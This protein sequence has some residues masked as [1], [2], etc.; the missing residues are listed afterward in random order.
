MKTRA[1]LVVVAVTA[2]LALAGCGGAASS[3]KTAKVDPAVQRVLRLAFFSDMATADPNVFYDIEG[4]AISQSVYDGLLRYRAGTTELEGALAE[5]WKVSGDRRT[6]T[7]ALRDAKFSDGSPVTSDAV[8]KSFER[9]TKVDQGPAYML[10]D[11]KRYVTPDPR[12]FVVELKQ[13][14]ASFA[15]LMASVWGP[16]VI[17]PSVLDKYSKDQAQ[18]HLKTNAAGTGP[19]MLTSWRPGKGYTLKR[20][21]NYWGKEPYFER[22]EIA[23][24]PDVSSQLLE[25]QRG[26]LDGVLHGVPLSS[27][28]SLKGKGGLKVERFD[29][30]GTVTLAINQDR[31]ELKDRAVREAL[32]R[33]L[34]VPTLV[35]NVWGESATAMKSA[36]PQPLLPSGAAPISYPYD[37]AAIKAAI[38]KGTKVEVVYSPDSSGVQRRFADLMRQQLGK[39]GVTVSPRQAE[40]SAVFAYRDNTAKA[41]DFYI[42]TPT[43]DAATPDAWARIVWHSGGGLNFFNYANK[44]VDA[45]MDQAVKE[46]D[47]ARAKA[48]YAE[49]GTMAVSEFGEAPIA[50]VKDTMVLRGDLTGVEHVPAY[51]WTLNLGELGRK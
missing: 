11:V 8:Q 51:P 44:Q 41:P 17:N 33:A 50:Q 30:L 46:P 32:V 7:F 14:V 48:L 12:T 47:E 9:L 29:S 22:V 6:Y 42:S 5:S 21:P 2:G 45:K 16:K 19:F 31:P 36:Y 4:D 15:D 39:V 28:Q 38:P 34:D 35:R 37:Q 40:L 49:A 43:P 10:A 18:K 23:V 1:S 13:P 27:V 20:N 25:L 26:D 3:D 24:K